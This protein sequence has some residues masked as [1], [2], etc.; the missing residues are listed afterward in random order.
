MAADSVS[1]RPVSVATTQSTTFKHTLMHINT[2][3]LSSKTSGVP[4]GSIH[5]VTSARL[6]DLLTMCD[7]IYSSQQYRETMA[8]NSD[9]SA[10][11]KARD[12]IS[13][14]LDDLHLGNCSFGPLVIPGPTASGKLSEANEEESDRYLFCREGCWSVL[15]DAHLQAG[16]QCVHPRVWEIRQLRGIQASVCVYVSIHSLHSIIGMCN[17]YREGGR[18]H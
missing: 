18:G 4:S 8:M 17:T 9:H 2:S 13:A 7:F 14:S 3:S 12:E 5:Q 1:A 6:D 16:R 10:V 15:N 11:L